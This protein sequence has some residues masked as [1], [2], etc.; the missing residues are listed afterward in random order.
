MTTDTSIILLYYRHTTVTDTGN[1]F[2]FT[3]SQKAFAPLVI[4]KNSASVTNFKFLWSH[5]SVT[6]C[7]TNMTPYVLHI[8]FTIHSTSVHFI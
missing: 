3:S 7:N 8:L 2:T 1:R 4:T 5:A 6:D